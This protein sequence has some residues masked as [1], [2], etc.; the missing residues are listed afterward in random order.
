MN[1]N[2]S[3]SGINAEQRGAAAESTFHDLMLLWLANMAPFHVSKTQPDTQKIDYL[4]RIPS[5]WRAADQVE[6]RWQIK[7]TD[8]EKIRLVS[9]GP[10]D[11]LC[12]RYEA[13]RKMMEGLY[14]ASRTGRLLLALAV[15]RDTEVPAYDLMYLPPTDRFDWYVLD[16][17]EYFR[18]VEWQKYGGAIFVPA[19]NRLNLATFSLLWSAHWVD[20]FFRV[21]VGS[22]VFSVPELASDIRTV[23]DERSSLELVRQYRW[24]FLQRRLPRY[25]KE[26]DPAEF[27]KI[28]F[29]TGLAGALG[30]IRERMHDAAACIDVV[31]NYCPEALFGTANLWLFST[32]YHH[33]M[34]ATY[35]ISRGKSEFTSERL[36]PLPNED[37]R[38]VP[39]VQL[40]TLWH[41]MLRYRALGTSVRLVTPPSVGAGADYSYYGGG[42]GYFPWIS[43]AENS[44]SWE[45]DVCSIRSMAD[46]I[47][48]L[49]ARRRETQLTLS[50]GGRKE[51]A[52]LFGI[53]EE[54]LVLPD[55]TPVL[56][57]PKESIFVRHPVEL[58]GADRLVLPQQ[59]L[60][61]HP[62]WS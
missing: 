53:R 23:F 6:F 20:G 52:R 54:D 37:A 24:D 5:L 56:M 29:R 43:L 22:D 27:A 10:L 14:E 18:R 33:F 15:Q 39:R 51:A 48:F 57:F 3:R 46:N 59:P 31:R 13:G 9:E 12:L 28:N 62:S 35:D 36:L 49:E 47:D 21:L 60:P 58:F 17:E 11:C 61:S 4:V 16:L 25:R 45:I 19:H 40:V 8:N 38:L 32:C 42:I 55:R 30:I 26:L 44:A 50:G 41:V 34:K 7:S 2:R 1:A